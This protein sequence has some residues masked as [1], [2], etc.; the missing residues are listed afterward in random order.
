MNELTVK[1]SVVPGTIECNMDETRAYLEG[2]VKAYDGAMFSEE[3]KREAKGELA[4]LRK[5]KD[6]LEGRRKEVK[7]EWL[8]PYEEFEKQAK[9][10]V[11]LINQPISLIDMQIKEMEKRRKEEK[12]GKICE[13]FGDIASD[14]LECV[15]L[16]KIY[17]SR[18]ENASVTEKAWKSDVS[19]AVQKIR[20]D[21]DVIKMNRSDALPQ[22]LET[23]KTSLNLG[24]ALSVIQTYERQKEDI[25]R[26]Q[27][28]KRKAEEAERIRRE[29][30]EKAAQ[31]VK[32]EVKGFGMPE[33]VEFATA[34]F[35]VE[36]VPDVD[37]VLSFD[38]GTCA[39][40]QIWGTEEEFKQL[41]IFLDSIGVTY[42]RGEQ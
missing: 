11:T 23:Y 34:G 13:F 25:L 2:V 12:R 1:V 19:N 40:Y 31:Q 39:S 41:E 36:C 5:M 35:D 20:N 15:S 33:P 6:A 9:E 17:D 29:E 30:R 32:D 24:M 38:A 3:S 16:E 27:E 8:K 14:I 4:S 21:I 10:L 28:E 42:K 7:A 37:D 22:A 18:W 26:R